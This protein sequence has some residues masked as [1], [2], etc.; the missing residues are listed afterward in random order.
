MWGFTSAIS[1]LA[2]YMIDNNLNIGNASPNVAID[3]AAPLYDFEEQRIETAFKCKVT[4]I[5]GT[6]EVGHIAARCPN[7]SMHTNQ[8][9]NCMWKPMHLKQLKMKLRVWKK[10]CALL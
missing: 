8:E 6:R 7:G 2:K 5:Y 1:E 9:L 4:N 10:F 3:W